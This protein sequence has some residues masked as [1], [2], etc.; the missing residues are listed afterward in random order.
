MAEEWLSEFREMKR[1]VTVAWSNC[2]CLPTLCYHLGLSS[3]ERVPV[4]KNSQGATSSL[5][6]RDGTLLPSGARSD[7]VA[8]GGWR[9]WGGLGTGGWGQI[10]GEGARRRAREQ[11]SE[12]VRCA[13]LCAVQFQ[14]AENKRSIFVD[15]LCDAGDPPDDKKLAKC[16]KSASKR[17]PKKPRSKRGGQK[18]RKNKKSRYV[19][20][21]VEKVRG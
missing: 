9:V 2:S 3:P 6:P 1:E 18:K 16:I 10:E 5:R 15:F 17:S 21:G 7:G 11:A 20:V 8:R 14:S 13:S 12:R 19:S 4:E